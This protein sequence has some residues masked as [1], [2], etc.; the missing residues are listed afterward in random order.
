MDTGVARRPIIDMDAYELNLKSRMD[1]TANIL[2]G[3]NARA[4][5]NQARMIFAEGD[6]P[7]VLRA[8]VLYQRSGLG[9]AL[10]VGREGD[11]KA[12]LEATGMDDAVAE[13]EIVNA[14]NTPHLETY[15]ARVLTQR[16]SIALQRAIVMFSAR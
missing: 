6:D 11:V 4:R 12:K 16:T 15:S 7:R 5:N 8:A 2:R 14:A 10:V 13:L 1:P 3:I 9:K